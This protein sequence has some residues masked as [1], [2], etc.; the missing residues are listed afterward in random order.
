MKVKVGFHCSQEQFPPSLMLDLVQRAESAGFD[1]AMSADHLAPWSERQGE[2]GLTWTWLGAAM[3]TTSFPMGVVTA[4]GQRYHPV[5]TA[6][7]LATTA[8]MFPGRF[9]A[10]LGSGLAANEHVTGDRWPTKAER[11]QRLAECIGIIRALLAGETVDHDGLVRVS[12]ARL[13]TLP[14]EPPPLIGA[15]LS[16][17]TAAFLAPMV[18]GLITINLP[19]DLLRKVIDA[20]RSNGGDGKPVYLQAHVSWAPTEDEALANAH[21][22]W[23]TNAFPGGVAEDIAVVSQFDALSELVQPEEVRGSVLVNGDLGWHVDTLAAYAELGF[24]AIFL[25]N[26]G[27]NQEAFIDTFADSVLPALRE[28]S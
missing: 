1:A 24:E 9:W 18:D 7:A 14:A 25:H 3:Q 13:W 27:R 26:V 23:R 4:P 20:F 2:S 21:D 5:I 12:E 11:N 19:D 15:A 17:E 28:R 16:P 8:E 10:A 6:Q 22:Q